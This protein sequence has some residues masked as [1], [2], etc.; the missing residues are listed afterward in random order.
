MPDPE[1]FEA[2]GLYDPTAADADDRLALLRYLSEA[3]ATIEEMIQAADADRLAPLAGDRILRPDSRRLT[4]DE[5]AEETGLEADTILRLWQAAG[6]APPPEGPFFYR[7]DVATFMAFHAGRDL[8]SA[9]AT[10]HLTRVVG[11]AMGRIAEAAVSSFLLN[12][13]ADLVNRGAPDLDYARANVEAMVALRGLTS[14]FEPLFHH[15]LEAAIRRSMMARSDPRRLDIVTLA[16]GFVDLV[17]FT[18]LS[19]EMTAED[20]GRLVTDFEELTNRIVGELGGRV[21]KTIGDEVMFAAADPDAACEVALRLVE[22]TG[23][24]PGLFGA[25]GGLA[26][27]DAVW[28]DGDYFGSSVNLGARLVALADPGTVLVND[29]L[30]RSTAGGA[31][32]FSPAGQ[33]WLKGFGEA[34]D[35][36]ELTRRG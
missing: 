20:L 26:L 5:M 7:E 18:S 36:F 34:V 6:F 12:V 35:I 4:V 31:F 9:G 28:R 2:A 23:S 10:Q 16:V 1:Q 8:L 15:H 3:G 21:V 27:G 22:E 33:R 14:I 13:E 17:A 11:A 19:Q 32:S 30:S 24:H 25:R 29:R